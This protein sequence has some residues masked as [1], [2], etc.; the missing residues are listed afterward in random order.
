VPAGRRPPAYRRRLGLAVVPEERLGRGAVAELDLTE[1]ALLTGAGLVR[2]GLVRRRA[3][4]AFA[5]QVIARFGVVARG[6]DAEARSLSGG[7]LQKFILGREILQ[8]PKLLVAAHPTW[9]VDVG[10][11]AEIHRALLALRDRGAAVLIVSEDLDELLA[12]ADRVAAISRGRLSPLLRADEND[13]TVR[14][15]IGEWMSGLFPAARDAA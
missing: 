14:Q 2:A 13:P 11:A 5:A 3:A 7:N 6:P 9:G 15:R 10:A 1:N 8:Q 12:I 4:A